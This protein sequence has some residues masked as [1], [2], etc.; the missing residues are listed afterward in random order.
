MIHGLFR[1]SH[2]CHKESTAS[3]TPYDEYPQSCP[4]FAISC[5][6]GLRFTP[7]GAK[8]DVHRTSCTPLLAHIG[9][10]Q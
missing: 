3:G 5:D 9:A 8:T 1:A 10:S 4:I 6:F 7:V 2:L